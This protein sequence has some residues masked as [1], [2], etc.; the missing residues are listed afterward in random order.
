MEI[1]KYEKYVCSECRRKY[2]SKQEA[3]E[4]EKEDKLKKQ[5]EDLMEFEIKEEHLKLLKEMCIGWNDCEFGAPEIDPKRPYGNSDGV[6]DVA[7]VIGYKK[8]KNTVEFDKEEAKEYDDVKEYLEECDWK[9]EA[10]DYLYNL[11][12]DMEIVLQIVLST[13]SFRKGK[14]KREDRYTS[15]WMEVSADSSQP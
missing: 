5:R 13:L 15:Q 4:C 14:Y 9:Q 6:D 8:D 2:E 10:Y 1:E 7:R 12:K 11:H 3:L